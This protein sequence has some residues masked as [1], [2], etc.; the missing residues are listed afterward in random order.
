MRK[1]NFI[2]PAIFMVLSS[3][4]IAQETTSRPGTITSPYAGILFGGCGVS[5]PVS[6]LAGIQ[7]TKHTHFS[8]LY[9]IYY[10]NTS[11]HDYSDNVFSKGHFSSLAP[12]VKFV[13]STG[14]KPGNGLFAGLGMGYMIARD[15]GTEQP[16]ITDPNT[17][18]TIL[19]N[20]DIVSGKWDFNSISP[21]MTFG[22]G[23]RL[24]HFPIALN[25]T[26]YFAKTTTGWDAVA[27]GIGLKMAFR[28]F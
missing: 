14:K 18:A 26:Y 6:F 7:Q 16:Y 27:G 15:R 9:D 23:F 10:W 19:N 22:I 11:Y 8:I 2:A 4:V 1:I 21:S 13:Y 3:S 28:K 20:K 17:S 24:F 12:S 5:N 25:N